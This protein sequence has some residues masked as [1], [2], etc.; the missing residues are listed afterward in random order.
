MIPG[1]AS[2]PDPRTGSTGAVPH[3]PGCDGLE[4]AQQLG[5][6]CLVVDAYAAA[7]AAEGY[8]VQVAGE[9]CLQQAAWSGGRLGLR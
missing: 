4:H 3:D 2:N 1:V 8:F 9:G 7:P 5:Q 6:G